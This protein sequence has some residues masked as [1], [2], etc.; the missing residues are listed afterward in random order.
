MEAGGGL[1]EFSREYKGGTPFI[2][3]K[4]QNHEDF[5]VTK[6]NIFFIYTTS[7]QNGKKNRGPDPKLRSSFCNRLF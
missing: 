3:T 7:R 5:S 6:A 4:S 2:S 1:H